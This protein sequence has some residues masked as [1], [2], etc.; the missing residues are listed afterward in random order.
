MLCAQ[1]RHK[2]Q[3]RSCRVTEQQPTGLGPRA[4]AKKRLGCVGCDARTKPLQTSD[5]PSQQ[6]QQQRTTRKHWTVQP[7][8][9]CSSTLEKGKPK[10]LFK[11]ASLTA[12]KSVPIPNQLRLVAGL[13]PVLATRVG[14]FNNPVFMLPS[15]IRSTC[16]CVHVRRRTKPHAAP[17]NF[18]PSNV[19]RLGVG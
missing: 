6:Q 5:V 14:R 18:E 16:C 11:D 3:R 2:A 9:G 8:E 15:T 17:A 19:S 1:P 4:A 12:L 7:N 10:V 13:L